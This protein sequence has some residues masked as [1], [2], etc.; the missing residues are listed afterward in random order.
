MLTDNEK[1]KAVR[2]YARKTNGTE[3]W[4]LPAGK[5]LIYTDGIK[6]LADTCGAYWLIDLV[7]SY[8]PQL[9]NEHFQV[10]RLRPYGNNGIIVDCWSDIPERQADEDGPASIKFC[11]QIIEYS[12]FPR[13]LLP[14]EFWVQHDTMLLKEEY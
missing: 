2:G 12:D 13:E 6:F 9:R 14:F 1:A 11:E 3:R 4:H 7:G 5:N 10:W 8:Q